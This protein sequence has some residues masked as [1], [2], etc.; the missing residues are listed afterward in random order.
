MLNRV[1]AGG[2]P[3]E[4]KSYALVMNFVRIVDK[5]VADYERT[6]A[7]L[8]EFV[9]TPNNVMAPLIYATNNCESCI[10]TIIRAIK[11]GR[12][13]RRDQNG[14]QIAKKLF[15]LSDSVSIKLNGIRNAIEHIDDHIA[16]DTWTPD[17]P[18]CLIIKNDRLEVVS[19]EITY[20][21]LADWVRQ[22]NE[23]AEKLA[24]YKEAS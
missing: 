16:S 9:N 10:T 22:L 14:P 18:I 8:T 21:E 4:Q 3:T 6:R 23:L 20:A 17:E 7:N 19:E 1:F 15:V 5:L 11:L 24:M 2:G 12:R 13:I